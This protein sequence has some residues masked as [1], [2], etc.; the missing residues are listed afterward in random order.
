MNKKISFLLLTISILSTLCMSVVLAESK[1]VFENKK[2]H[3][4]PI[5]SNLPTE[6]TSLSK[7]NNVVPLD[8]DENTITVTLKDTDESD[9]Y[10][11]S[12]YDVTEGKYIT[13][14]T[15][16]AV[17]PGEFTVSGLTGG[18]EYTVKAS[19]FFKEQNLSG[20]IITSYTDVN[21]DGKENE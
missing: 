1:I 11:I 12:I 4:Y 13:A 20:E 5:F 10:F 17:Y 21:A 19:S 18:H 7:V 9:I 8:K 3:L 15:G 2:T 16:V 14:S 6:Y